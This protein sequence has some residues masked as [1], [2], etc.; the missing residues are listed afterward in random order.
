MIIFAS[1]EL[2]IN[3]NHEYI[4]FMRLLRNKLLI[5][6]LLVVVIAASCDK[7]AGYGGTSSITGTITTKYYNDDHSLVIRQGAAVDEDIFLLFGESDI[8]GD[9]VATG[10]GGKFA[11]NYLR[12]GTYT[13]YYLSE[14]I[15]SAGTEDEVVSIAVELTEG[16]DYDLGDLVINKTLD[17]NDGTARISGTIRL[18]NYKNSSTYPFL[19]VKDT[20]YAQEQ[21][22]YLVYGDHEFYDERIRTSYDGYF[23]FNKLIKGDYKIFT[24][25]EDITGGTEDIPIIKE[26]SITGETDE[27]DL[28]LIYIE[29]L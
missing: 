26:V 11:F 14:D 13:V 10:P 25:S 18:V 16:M 15:T 9:K 1:C 7:P 28:G 5:V 8:V 19:E 2:R 23:E 21:E 12:P 22:V 17:Y 27:I 6:I 3:Q 4:D 29:K 24:Y 20:S